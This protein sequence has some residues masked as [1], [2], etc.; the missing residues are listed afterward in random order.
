MNRIFTRPL[1]LSTFALLASCAIS[2]PNP[3]PSQFFSNIKLGD[4]LDSSMIRKIPDIGYLEGGN[5]TSGEEGGEQH[6]YSHQRKEAHFQYYF[7]GPEKADI[8][9]R[10]MADE[11]DR[12]I[13]GSDVRNNSRGIN[14]PHN[15]LGTRKIEKYYSKVKDGWYTEGTIRILAI[16]GGKTE[17]GEA[18]SL[19]VFIDEVTARTG[20]SN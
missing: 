8:L 13:F 3:P 6:N 20:A 19:M 9:A 18:V 4:M 10:Y 2:S 15:N 16:E 12:L 7:T 14:D 11:I 5:G 1:F 17:K